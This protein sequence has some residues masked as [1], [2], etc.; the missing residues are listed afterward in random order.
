[1]EVIDA[2]TSHSPISPARDEQLV[3]SQGFL[4]SQPSAAASLRERPPVVV[5]LTQ[6][7]LEI[8]NEASFSMI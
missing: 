6:E 3:N 2:S 8:Y 5:P 7:D 4:V 1:M